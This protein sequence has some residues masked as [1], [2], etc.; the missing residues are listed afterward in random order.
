VCSQFIYDRLTMVDMPDVSQAMNELRERVKEIEQPQSDKPRVC[1]GPPAGPK[2]VSAAD[3]ARQTRQNGDLAAEHSAT[4][5]GWFYQQ[6]RNKGTW[7][8]KQYDRAYLAYGNYNY[9]Y[10]GAR[11]GIPAPIL[12][13]A[14]GYAQVRAGTS[15]W[16]F[17]STAFDDR[18]D[19][20]WID[21]GI[22]DAKNGCF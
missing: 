21:R 14:A 13:G 19:R 18:E 7:D 8:Y 1:F 9:G 4:D 16:S 12:R 20:E 22:H 15:D 6:V 11:Q 3:L 17:W 10:A 5:L 2:G